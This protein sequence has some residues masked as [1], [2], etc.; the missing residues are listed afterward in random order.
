MKEVDLS[1]ELMTTKQKLMSARLQ[2]DA[3][4]KSAKTAWETYYENIL[5]LLDAP[6]LTRMKFLLTGKMY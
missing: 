3:Q 6:F 1:E 2:L 5:F 4:T